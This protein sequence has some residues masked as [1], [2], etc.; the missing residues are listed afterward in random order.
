MGAR[1]NVVFYNNSNNGK[2]YSPVI[3][4]HWYGSNMQDILNEFKDIYE[5]DT[6]DTNFYPAMRVEI[7]RVFPVFTKLLNAYEVEYCVNN[8]DNA[9]DFINEL[10][11]SNDMPMIADDYGLFL[12]DIKT[13]EIVKSEYD[14]AKYEYKKPRFLS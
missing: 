7:D 14:W 6:S 3:Y 9:K 2:E 1:A 10:P 11:S 4:T 8:F 13:M 5:S 12:V